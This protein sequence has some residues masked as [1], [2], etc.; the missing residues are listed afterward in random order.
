MTFYTL[1]ELEQKPRLLRYSNR[2]LFVSC[3]LLVVTTAVCYPFSA[4]FS[5]TEQLL[6]HL[7]MLG[8]GVLIKLSYLV[9]CIAQ[10]ALNTEVG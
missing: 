10:H 1:F 4:Y 9:R 7:L 3:V 5:L 8:S 6:S 2:G